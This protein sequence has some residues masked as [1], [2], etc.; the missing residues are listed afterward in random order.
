MSRLFGRN[1]LLPAPR[2][3]AERP[4][5]GRGAA[6]ARDRRDEPPLRQERHT[7]PARDER[8]L[9]PY[10]RGHAAR[11]AI[12]GTLPRS[13]AR[14]SIRTVAGLEHVLNPE[15][16]EEG[17][18]HHQQERPRSE[19]EAGASPPAFFMLGHSRSAMRTRDGS[20]PLTVIWS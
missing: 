7:H 14:T 2:S 4:D 16:G 19:I 17:Q 5:R 1:S 3:R 9:V 8:R 6:D 15:R 11:S 18:R 12:V 10:E 20:R 13:D